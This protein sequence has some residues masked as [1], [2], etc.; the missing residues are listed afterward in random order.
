MGGRSAGD[1]LTAAHED[2]G[3]PRTGTHPTGL[4]GYGVGAPNCIIHQ[5]V[6][7]MLGHRLLDWVGV[8]R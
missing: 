1:P 5:Q 4:N 6:L 3:F 8:A 2:D 7:L